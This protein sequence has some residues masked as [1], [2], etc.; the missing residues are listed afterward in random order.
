MVRR[1]INEE[2]GN[3]VEG[4]Y[5]LARGYLDGVLVPE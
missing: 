1:G 2:E 5:S 4:A 3:V